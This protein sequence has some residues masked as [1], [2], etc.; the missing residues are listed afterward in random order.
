M[1]DDDFEKEFPALAEEMARGTTRTHRIDG[2][3]TMSDEAD[4]PDDKETFM[5]NIIDYIRRCDTVN[6][7]L[8]IVEYMLKR[9]EISSMKAKE[10][11]AQLKRDGL[12]SFGTKK[13][14]GHYLHHGLEEE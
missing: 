1:T 4:Q 3:R 10:I 13:E 11:K 7:A 2:V 6:Q 8:E 9:E 5:P 14:K 12:R